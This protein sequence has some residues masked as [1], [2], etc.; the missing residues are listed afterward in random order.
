LVRNNNQLYFDAFYKKILCEVVVMDF[1]AFLNDP[2]RL[3][4]TLSAI[5]SI[6]I[7][8]LALS[9]DNA[10]VIGLAIKD[11]PAVRRRQAALIGTGAAL[12]LRVIFTAIATILTRIPFINAI[13]GIILVWITWKLIMPGKSDEEHVKGSDKF[14]GAIFAIIVADMSM[15]FDNVMGVAGAAH[16][17]ILLVIFGLLLSI[18]ILVFGSSWLATWMNRQPF[19]IYIGGAVL[20]HT[21]IAMIFH[22]KGLNLVNTLGELP[23]LIIP[24]LFALAV[25]VFGWVETKK[26]RLRAMPK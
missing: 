13:G 12:L 20:A 15:A 22:D 25:L 2:A 19:I 3:W 24:W 6:A 5:L 17:S 9:G 23:T 26:M 11:L 14:W 8:D 4:E 10:A 18:P 1:L 21:S 7:I 16:G